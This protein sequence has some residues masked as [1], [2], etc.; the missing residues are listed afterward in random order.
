MTTR[1]S[2]SLSLSR[3]IFFGELMFVPQPCFVLNRG[4]F[5]RESSI[6]INVFVVDQ[7]EIIKTSWAGIKRKRL[8]CIHS[9]E[10]LIYLLLYEGV[11]VYEWRQY[12]YVC[13]CKFCKGEQGILSKQYHV[14]FLTQRAWY[15]LQKCGEEFSIAF[16]RS[17]RI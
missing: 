16:C 17:V 11:Y 6:S 7:I 2:Y 12:V 3:M 13:F 9:M 10:D 1:L 15:T 14:Q 4:V 5:L 8:I